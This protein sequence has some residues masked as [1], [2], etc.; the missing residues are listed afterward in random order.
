MIILLIAIVTPIIAVIVAVLAAGGVAVLLLA[1]PHAAIVAAFPAAAVG[2]NRVGHDLQEL[3]RHRW[4][5]AMDDQ[6]TRSWTFFRRLV[7]DNRAQAGT[8]MEGRWEWIVNQLPMSVPVPE[9]HARDMKL[10][11]AHIAD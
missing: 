2:P 1:F 5:I 4:V 10:A 6:I 7:A 9:R 8:R 3:D 11:V